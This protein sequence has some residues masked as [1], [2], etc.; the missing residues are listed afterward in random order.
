MPAPLDHSF[1]P[2]NIL[3]VP[4]AR[5]AVDLTETLEKAA[6]GIRAEKLAQSA[7]GLLLRLAESIKEFEAR[8]D[9]DVEVGIS[10]ASFGQTITIHVKA[11]G[12][13]DPNLI[14]V[15]GLT[16]ASEPVQ[17]VQHMSQL[18]FLLMRVPRLAPETPRQPIGFSI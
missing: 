2:A 10:L 12:C 15:E 16:A 5:A 8:L 13:I 14:V 7:E 3:A 6:A 1:M 18:S 17:L 4:N 9:P 11:I